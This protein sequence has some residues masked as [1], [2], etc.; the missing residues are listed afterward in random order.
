MRHSGT[1]VLPQRSTLLR[2]VAKFPARAMLPTGQQ[3]GR[4]PWHRWP[5]G[6]LTP[7]LPVAALTPP[8]PAFARLLA[9]TEPRVIKQ[10]R[11]ATDGA[12]SSAHGGEATD[13]LGDGRRQTDSPETPDARP[14]NHDKGTVRAHQGGRGVGG[15]SRAARWVRLLGSVTGPGSKRRSPKGPCPRVSVYLERVL[16]DVET[17]GRAPYGR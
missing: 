3:G 11:A 1:P 8:S 10:N 4:R 16:A 7:A 12:V 13:M 17:S 9:D 14:S 15:R 2:C 6:P 5:P